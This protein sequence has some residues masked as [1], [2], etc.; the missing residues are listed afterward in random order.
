LPIVQT[1][2]TRPGS[3]SEVEGEV[4]TQQRLERA[5][6][7]LPSITRELLLLKLSGQSVSD[8]AT[9]QSLPVPVVKK[10]L[11]QALANIGMHITANGEPKF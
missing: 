4:D 10:R 1:E 5:F 7:A 2:S 9:A 3:T 11:A 6:G 8:I